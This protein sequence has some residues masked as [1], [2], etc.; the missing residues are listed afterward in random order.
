MFEPR[1][2]GW[3]Q[4]DQ[5]RIDALKLEEYLSELSALVLNKNWAHDILETIL[6]SKQGNQVFIDWKIEMENLNTILTTSSS[7]HAL[8][9]EPLKV[10]LQSNLHPDLRHNLNNEPTI[11]TNLAAWSIEVKECDNWM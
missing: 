2:V 3:Y 7:K 6:S 11:S 4:A 9:K 8:T 1:L 5:A 10:Q